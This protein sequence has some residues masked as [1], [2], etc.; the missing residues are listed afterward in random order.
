MSGQLPFQ[1]AQSAFIDEV[2][3]RNLQLDAPSKRRTRTA[4]SARG[5]KFLALTP[6]LLSPCDFT[7]SQCVTHPQVLHRTNRRDLSPQQ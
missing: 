1:V 5:S 6:T 4:P 3:S 7:G 2:Q